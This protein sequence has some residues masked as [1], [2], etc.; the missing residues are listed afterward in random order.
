VSLHASDRALLAAILYRLPR[1]VLAH[2]HLVVKPD[3][4]L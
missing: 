1:S 4:V 3:T 2:L